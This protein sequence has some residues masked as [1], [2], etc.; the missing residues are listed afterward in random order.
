MTTSPAPALLRTVEV[1]PIPIFFTNV[2]R[3]M[4]LRAHSHTGAVTVVYD[5][6]GRHG[7][8]SFAVTNAALERHIHELTRTVFKDAT[9]EDIADRLFAHLDGYVAREWEE[10]GGDY[11]L[12][13]IHLDVIGVHDAI[14]HDNSTTRYTVARSQGA[15]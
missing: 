2:N 5:T 4:G 14:G 10:W 3:P 8:P 13:A 7:Y 1:G 11:R 9:N 15:H 6:T 12:H